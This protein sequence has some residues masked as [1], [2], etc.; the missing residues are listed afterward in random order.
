MDMPC[1]SV[2]RTGGRWGVTQNGPDGFVAKFTLWQDAIDYARGLAVESRNSIVEGEDSRGRVTLR[3]IF[4]TDT[5]G[6]V[7]VQ[8]DP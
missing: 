7:R 4:W 1:I 3:Q 8:E 5:A 6:T 2:R